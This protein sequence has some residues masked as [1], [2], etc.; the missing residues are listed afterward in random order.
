M[1][2]LTE[3]F[4]QKIYPNED[5]MN[6]F[7]MIGKNLNIF[8]TIII[9]NV[10][11]NQE[12]R[13]KSIN[14]VGCLIVL[15]DYLGLSTNETEKNLFLKEIEGLKKEEIYLIMWKKVIEIREQMNINNFEKEIIRKNKDRLAGK[16]DI[17]IKDLPIIPDDIVPARWM[18]DRWWNKLIH[19][20]FQEK[21]DADKRIQKQADDI[22]KNTE[23]H[24]I[25]FPNLSNIEAI[26]KLKSEL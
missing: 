23:A 26:D 2:K 4:N 5:I 1:E 22:R 17:D 11:G 6:L 10:S 18:I 19:E 24:I 3:L 21:I 20:I 13:Y 15:L 12:N 7:L 14:G 25:W 9:K 16:K 8:D